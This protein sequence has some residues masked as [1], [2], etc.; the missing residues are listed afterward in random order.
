MAKGQPVY[1]KQLMYGQVIYMMAHLTPTH[2]DPSSL[3]IGSHLRMYVPL[4]LILDAS[5]RVQ[6]RLGKIIDR[7]EV[8]ERRYKPYS[9]RS[10]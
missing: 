6:L 8:G 1:T 10:F 5:M 7:W 9:N 3:N 4:T 2:K